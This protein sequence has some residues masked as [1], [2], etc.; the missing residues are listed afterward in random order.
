MVTAVRSFPSNAY[1]QSTQQE[2]TVQRHPRRKECLPATL[3]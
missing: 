2:R 1:Q 3:A